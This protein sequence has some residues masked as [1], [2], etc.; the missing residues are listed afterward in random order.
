MKYLIPMTFLCLA[1]AGCDGPEALEDGS[2]AHPAN[3]GA[4]QTP[5]APPTDTLKITYSKKDPFEIAPVAVE[6]PMKTDQHPSSS[7]D[8]R[9]APS[10]TE[11][12]PTAPSKEQ[13]P[14]HAEHRK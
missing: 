13:K 4:L 11:P 1:I 12:A 14:E 10:K 6:A 3:P 5:S 9:M 7:P 8:S 2:A